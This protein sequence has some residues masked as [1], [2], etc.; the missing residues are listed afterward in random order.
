MTRCELR[1]AVVV[2]DSLHAVAVAAAAA[3]VA[4]LYQHRPGRALLP[5]AA[6]AP[7]EAP[8]SGSVQLQSQGCEGVLSTGT[9]L[10]LCFSNR[11]FY[12]LYLFTPP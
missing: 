2:H 3:P 12:V 11:G 1:A 4:A 9:A 10:G 7:D 6:A 5:A 8:S